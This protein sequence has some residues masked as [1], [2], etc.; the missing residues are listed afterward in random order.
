M[1][2]LVTGANGFLGSHVAEALA[3]QGHDLRLLVRST[4]KLDF[5]DGLRAQ[6][7]EGDLRRPETLA[8]AL[9]DVDVVVHSAGL[10]S[11]RSEA[12]Y[13]T[14]NQAGTAALVAAC[15]KAGIRRLVYVSSLAAR[16][17]NPDGRMDNAGELRPI[18][19]YGRSKLGGENAVLAAADRISVAS[20]R[21]PV[22]Y[23]P[24]DRALL[25]FFRLVKLRVMPLF[26]AGTNRLSWIN[27]LDAAG[28]IASV[29]QAEG[30]SGAVYTISDGGAYSW[31]DLADMLGRSLGRQSLRIKTPPLLY[32]SAG[33]AA[34][35]AAALV[36]KPLPLTLEKVTEMAQP[37]WTCD[38]ER[39]A[40]DFDWQPRL[41]AQSGIDLTVRWYREH[42]WA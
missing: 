14:V 9:V 18:S 16:G 39:I 41:D 10:T 30:P 5:I 33:Y 31:N 34:D 12:E 36:R 3:A 22:I 27:V 26:G 42:G 13:Q 28:A 2:V 19:A 6:R 25:P 11:A 23:G 20:V 40:A 1:R 7:V 35:L 24:R 17:P 15:L 38:N 21:P 32:R 29:A 4:S 8:A 37:Y